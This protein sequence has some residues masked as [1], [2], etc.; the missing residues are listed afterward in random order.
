[1]TTPELLAKWA[2]VLNFTNDR[3]RPIPDEQ[4]EYVASQLEMYEKKFKSYPKCLKILIPQVREHF[5]K[6]FHYMD[7]VEGEVCVIMNGTSA[8]NYHKR[9]LIAIPLIPEFDI[10]PFLYQWDQFYTYNE[11]SGSWVWG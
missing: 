5:E 1:M 3:I 2:T 4:L 6:L 11:D 10:H 9:R 7:I 8:S